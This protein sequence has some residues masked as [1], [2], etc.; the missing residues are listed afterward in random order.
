MG[1]GSSKKQATNANQ[2]VQ[3]TF[4]PVQ[5]QVPDNRPIQRSS[6]MMTSPSPVDGQSGFKPDRTLSI[7]A[8]PTP[9]KH[10]Q[11]TIDRR[12]TSSPI[13][14]KH[15][16]SFRASNN[17]SPQ[18][19]DDI[20]LPHINKAANRSGTRSSTHT[21][22]VSPAVP[23]ERPQT[24]SRSLYGSQ[25]GANHSSSATPHGHDHYY[26]NHCPHCRRQSQ[27]SRKATPAPKW[28]TEKPGNVPFS[29]DMD[30][31]DSEAVK[32]KVIDENGHV[33]GSYD[34]RP[35]L[36]LEQSDDYD[37]RKENYFTQTLVAKTS[38]NVS[39]V[40]TPFPENNVLQRRERRINKPYGLPLFAD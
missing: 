12:M 18:D 40:R 24:G 14:D 15:G 34:Y 37:V 38:P 23:S 5:Q 2:P 7:I 27:I 8:S 39:P 28:L 30:K 13:Y 11:R 1:G 21:S 3:S 20:A 26:C 10:S 36:T 16:A 31:Y 4:P 29:I 17:N 19:G 22:T 25:K 32:E 35:Q 33:P 6:P 9:S